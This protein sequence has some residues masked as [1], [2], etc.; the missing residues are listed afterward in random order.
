MRTRVI[1]PVVGEFVGGEPTAIRYLQVALNEAG[2]RDITSMTFTDKKDATTVS[3]SRMDTK[4][5][6]YGVSLNG[7]KPSLLEVVEV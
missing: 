4:G 1:R 3:I 6:V 5:E 2:D 7:K